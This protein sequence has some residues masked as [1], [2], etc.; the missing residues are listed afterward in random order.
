MAETLTK[1][2]QDAAF[3][4]AEH[5][6][7]LDMLE[8]G[9]KHFAKAHRKY[10]IEP[11]QTRERLIIKDAKATIIGI[12]TNGNSVQVADWTEHEDGIALIPRSGGIGRTVL[13]S[14]VLGNYLMRRYLHKEGTP[15]EHPIVGL[16]IPKG[17]TVEIDAL[18][19]AFLA[20]DY[21]GDLFVSNSPELRVGALAVN[22]A[23]LVMEGH[24]GFKLGNAR[25]G[26]D[27]IMADYSWGVVQQGHVYV[28]AFD[29]AHLIANIDGHNKIDAYAIDQAGIWDFQGRNK[30]GKWDGITS[31]TWQVLTD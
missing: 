10:T 23:H 27:C 31:E 25:A 8:I 13:K 17:T 28:N 26:A 9:K 29:Q 30:T 12:P 5:S 19:G 3:S 24:S 11:E 14:I 1:P 15:E 18:E 16:K 7:I 20:G 4:R 6:L 21:E 22:Y 2:V